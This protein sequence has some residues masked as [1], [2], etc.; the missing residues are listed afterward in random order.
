VHS[1]I[2]VLGAAAVGLFLVW[3]IGYVP[4]NMDEFNQAHALAC[5]YPNSHLNSRTAFLEGCDSY[6]LDFGFFSYHRSYRYV[7]ITSSLLYFPLWSVWRSP[8]SYYLLGLLLLLAFSLAIV[9]ALGLRWKYALIPLC[10]F[11]IAYS[12][13]HDTGP[14]RL[15]LLS[16]P[17]VVL[18]L[19]RL[20]DDS[21]VSHK[22]ACAVTCATLM[23]LCVEDKPFYVYLLPTLALFAAACLA[24]A[25][26]GGGLVAA[27]TAPT[28][29]LPLLALTVAFLAGVGLLLFA[30]R[31]EGQTYF[32]YL[33]TAAAKLPRARVAKR[34]VWFTLSFA[35]FGH[36]VFEV[37]GTEPWARMAS[38]AA[39]AVSAAW[40]AC[41]AWRGRAVRRV[42]LILF[43]LSYVTGVVVFLVTR[44]TYHGHHYVFLH[45][46]A[47]ALLL[48]VARANAGRFALVLGSVVVLNLGSVA[49]LAATSI[50]PRSVPERAEIFRYLS[51]PDVARSS[52]IT[53]SGFGGYYQQ[54][55]YG[56]DSQV[57]T[58]S[59][60]RGRRAR[61]AA[62]EL[63]RLTRQTSR[64]IINVCMRCDAASVRALHETENVVEIDL[65]LR[66][67]KVFQVDPN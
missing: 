45:L 54:A 59:R 52:I 37:F 42:P 29:R 60:D 16:F 9:R 7:G 6:L 63:R 50:E 25:K 64:T 24:Q 57:V 23:T 56:D 34:I 10:Y 48:L 13:I 27:V 17:V 40:I 51:R 26:P 30:G 62:A 33:S 44:T 36:R 55:L 20:L 22:L 67:W 46:P 19:K 38:G 3:S 28:N 1:G 4:A 2:A 66:Q 18:L 39:T 21:A 32:E 49:L 11:P 41:V 12:F 47:L 53:F 15:S 31:T 35:T 58:W 65:G 61:V 14:V 5:R 8:L 43:V